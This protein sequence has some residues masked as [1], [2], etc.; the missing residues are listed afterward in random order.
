MVDAAASLAEARCAVPCAGLMG[1]WGECCDLSMVHLCFHCHVQE[2]QATREGGTRIGIS[3]AAGAAAAAAS[4]Q[5]PNLFENGY[6]CMYEDS[7]QT[8]AG[9][10][11]DIADC[12][13]KWKDSEAADPLEVMENGSCLD[14]RG[15]TTFGRMLAA[16]S[17]SCT[18]DGADP[19]SKEL[20]FWHCSDPNLTDIL[21]EVT[22]L[23]FEVFDDQWTCFANLALD[24]YTGGALVLWL[25]IFV[26]VLMS[27]ELSCLLLHVMRCC[28]WQVGGNPQQHPR[29]TQRLIGWRPCNWMRTKP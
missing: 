4:T 16:L 25:L 22:V 28:S 20:C 23:V 12:I 8:I 21:W 26:L 29:R 5:D 14:V 6:E 11:N 24:M 13:V 2:W 15:H 18:C 10:L 19:E 27:R 17:E 3:F 1:G 7:A 9:K